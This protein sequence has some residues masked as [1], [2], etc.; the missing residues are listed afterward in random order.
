VDLKSK[1]SY[2]EHGDQDFIVLYVTYIY[3]EL[4]RPC[5]LLVENLHQIDFFKGQISECILKLENDQLI[6]ELKA[7]NDSLHDC[8]QQSFVTVDEILKET[9]C[10]VGVT[11]ENFTTWQARAKTFNLKPKYFRAEC[12]SI[13]KTDKNADCIEKLVFAILSHIGKVMFC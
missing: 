6:E 1:I 13:P 11:C 12:L 8:I 5:N 4:I 10:K 7:I 2:A 3:F 9:V